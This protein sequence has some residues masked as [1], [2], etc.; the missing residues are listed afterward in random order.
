M[1]TNKVKEVYRKYLK[2]RVL[3]YTVSGPERPL[4]C[5]PDLANKDTAC[6]VKTEFQSKTNTLQYKYISHATWDIYIY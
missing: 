4:W 5:M 2:G 3:F 6:L 1:E